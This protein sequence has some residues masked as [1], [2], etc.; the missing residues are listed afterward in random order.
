MASPPSVINLSAVRIEIALTLLT[1]NRFDA[2]KEKSGEKFSSHELEMG[3]KGERPARV[4]S[5][6]RT[7]TVANGK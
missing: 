3:R 2:K 5:F 1:V 4:G 6:F 7:T